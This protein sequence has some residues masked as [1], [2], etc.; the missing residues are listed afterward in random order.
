MMCCN[1]CPF[2]PTSGNAAERCP[3]PV[4]SP[5]SERCN[6]GFCARHLGSRCFMDLYVINRLNHG[7]ELAEKLVFDS[8]KS[9]LHGRDRSL[10]LAIFQAAGEALCMKLWHWLEV[11]EPR[12]LW[13]LN[14]VFS[15][16]GL[17]P[18]DSFARVGNRRVSYLNAI[19]SHQAIMAAT[20]SATHSACQEELV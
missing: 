1:E 20:V 5:T 11:Y 7:D 9:A 19:T 14:P 4:C 6:T 10:V 3:R 16:A 12:S 13:L 15:A 18:L 8:L 17:R 2:N